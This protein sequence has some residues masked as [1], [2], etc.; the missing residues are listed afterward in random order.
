MGC[1]KGEGSARRRTDVRKK[2]GRKEENMQ[3]GRRR[4]EGGGEREGERREPGPFRFIYQHEPTP[5][6]RH[7]AHQIRHRG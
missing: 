6:R 1:V 7:G 2:E 5:H 3:E 4:M